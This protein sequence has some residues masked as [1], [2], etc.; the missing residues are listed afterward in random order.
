MPSMTIEK[1]G[2][3]AGSR[4]DPGV[5]NVLRMVLGSSRADGVGA[6][7]SVIEIAADIDD[8]TPEMLGF[9]HERLASAGALDVFLSPVTMKKGRPGVEVRILCQEGAFDAVVG[10]VF[11]ETTTFGVRFCRKERIVLDRGF[12]RVKTPFGVVRVKVG[13]LGGRIVSLSPEFEDCRAVAARKGI[14]LRKV[15]AE[16]SR[17]AERLVERSGSE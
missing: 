7:E 3:G 9:L 5:P 10:A 14:P 12:V 17:A 11:A 13:R 2:Y 6:T 1:V 8:S 15:Y 4:D 16:A